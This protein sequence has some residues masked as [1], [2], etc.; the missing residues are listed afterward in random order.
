[1][2]IP[3]QKERTFLM[4]PEKEITGKLVEEFINKHRNLCQ[5]YESLENFYTGEHDIYKD[6]DKPIGK[7]DNR[8]GVNFARY[9]VDTA[10]GYFV[11]NP[12][13]FSHKDKK[14]KEK[15]D[16]FRKRNYEEDNDAEV[17]KN[18]A[19][20][21][22]GYKVL[23]QDE[24]GETRSV[25]ITPREGFIVYSKDLKRK[26]VFG[27]IYKETREND[28]T[29]RIR[30]YVY[31]KDKV[32]EYD[33][34][35]HTLAETEKAAEFGQDYFYEDVPMI[36][37]IE[38]QEKQGRIEL[39]W[40]LVNNYNRA[41]SE[42]ANDVAY[43][44]DAYL[45]MIGVDIK[46][47]NGE[48]DPVLKGLRDNRI[49]SSERPLQQGQSVDIGF[50]EKPNADGTQEN[51][52]NRLERLIYQMSMTYNSNDETLISNASGKALGFKLQDM[53]NSTL[54]K[55]RKFKKANALQYKMVLQTDPSITDKTAWIDIEQKFT[56]SEPRDL[57]EEAETARAMAGITSREKQLEVLSS[58]TDVHQEMKRIE[59]E[60]GDNRSDLEKM[61]EI[62][63]IEPKSELKDENDE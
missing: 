57:K 62:M 2:Q 46:P 10:T 52:L 45:K 25:V 22:L 11:G 27:F 7:P 13:K 63:E 9:V 50:L 58:V 8:I 18:S 48:N 40:S 16:D 20:Y 53:K 19:L 3:S 31:T 32:L 33:S 59:E 39:I 26:P 36:E 37:Y 51:L 61:G 4:D 29:V 42:K 12:I 30:G 21:G 54:T 55:E 60:E 1:M 49:I 47:K 5:F 15:I 41:L 23:Y 17:A 34:F 43:F 6:K 14:I 24:E 56:Y 28:S 38:N 35:G 44:A